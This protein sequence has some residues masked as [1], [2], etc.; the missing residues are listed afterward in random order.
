MPETHE[1]NYDHKWYVMAAVAMSIF[2]ATIDG[3][4]VNVA[5]PTLVREP[6]RPGTVQGCPLN[7]TTATP[8]GRSVLDLGAVTSPLSVMAT[9]WDGTGARVEL[10]ALARADDP[11]DEA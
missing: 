3:S 7:F 6:G 1:I 8:P 11:L 9:M 2:L 4:I 10:A 5:L